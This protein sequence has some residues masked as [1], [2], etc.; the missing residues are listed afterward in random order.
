MAMNKARNKRLEA[1]W[2]REWADSG[3]AGI[4][5]QELLLRSTFMSHHNKHDHGQNGSHSSQRESQ[6]ALAYQLWDHAGRPE[7]QAERFW[8]EAEAQIKVSRR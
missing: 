3:S 1:Y 7:G 2:P 5:G 4:A 6:E 8:L